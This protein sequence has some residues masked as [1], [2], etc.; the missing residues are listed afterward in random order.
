MDDYPTLYILDFDGTL[1]DTGGIIRASMH[2]AFA[3][4]GLPDRTDADCD[5]TIG[6]PL[7]VGFARLFPDASAGDLPARYVAIY[8]RRFDELNVPGAVPLFPKVAETL[9]SLRARGARI[10]IASSRH[11]RTLDIFVRD[12]GLSPWID[13]VLGGEDAPRPKPDPALVL[14]VQCRFGADPASTVVVGDTPYDME[15]GRR[16]GCRVIGATYGYGA[17]KALIDAGADAL[18]GD[19]ATLPLLRPALGARLRE[20]IPERRFAHTLGVAD[21]AVRLARRFGADEG[22]AWLAGMLHDCAKGIPTEKQAETCDRLG[23]AIDDEV[24]RCPSVIHGFLGAHLARTVYGVD[25]PVVLRAIELHTIG[26][27]GMSLLQRIVFLADS[28]EPG[29]NFPGVDAMRAAAENNLDEALRL[30]VGGQFGHLVEK[31]AI[32]HSGLLRLWNDLVGTP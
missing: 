27:A 23:V 19:F 7:E 11:R 26:D 20:A 21:E 12:L 1:A 16:A 6:L 15:M 9:E 3:A 5:T 24:R 13:A 30:F 28:T 29:R 10:A 14:K 25:D 22:R 31:R 8:R 32:M 2:H 4:L 18:L 17:R